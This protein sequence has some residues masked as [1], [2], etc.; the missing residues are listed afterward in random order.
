MEIASKKPGEVTVAKSQTT[1]SSQEGRHQPN[2]RPL[3]TNQGPQGHS[4]R[5]ADPALALAGGP[6][7]PRDARRRLHGEDSAHSEEVAGD[8]IEAFPGWQSLDS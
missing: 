5:H 4:L 6:T 7:E 2:L 3:Q 8:S 1:A